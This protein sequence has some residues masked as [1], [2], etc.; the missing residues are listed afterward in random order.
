MRNAVKRVFY[1]ACGASVRPKSGRPTWRLAEE[2][3]DE[4]RRPNQEVGL[5]WEESIRH[6]WRF[7]QLRVGE[8]E[9]GRSQTSRKSL[10]VA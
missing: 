2:Q 5:K 9:R 10:K 7:R 1:V 4:A 8:G 3:A 6:R